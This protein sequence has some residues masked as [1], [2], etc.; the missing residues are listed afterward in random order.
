MPLRLLLLVTVGLLLGAC[1][2]TNPYDP[3]PKTLGVKA[4][5][6]EDVT[7]WRELS[8]LYAFMAP[9]KVTEIPEGLDRVRVS[10]Y[11]SSGLRQTGPWRWEQT[12]VIDYVLTDRQVV[13]RVVDRQIWVSDD[14]GKTWYR[15]NPPPDFFQ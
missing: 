10:H 13:K 15:E 8:K 12:A 9:G 5:A 4:D 14:E 3:V 1:M 7:R 2:A 6:Y 11:E